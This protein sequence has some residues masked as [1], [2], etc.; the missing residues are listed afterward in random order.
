M[1]LLLSAPRRWR[2][3]RVRRRLISDG[4]SGVGP[5]SLPPPLPPEA[6]RVVEAV[7]TRHGRGDKEMPK[8]D[9]LYLPVHLIQPE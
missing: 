5:V 3:A 7:L 4:L 1:R 8:V 6:G 2:P 9:S